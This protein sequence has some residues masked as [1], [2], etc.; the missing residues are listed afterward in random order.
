MDLCHGVFLCGGGKASNDTIEAGSKS[1]NHYHIENASKQC[2]VFWK[3]THFEYFWKFQKQRG[4][5]IPH[6][7]YELNP[8]NSFKYSN[9]FMQQQQYRVD[10][11]AQ[12]PA[13]KLKT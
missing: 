5:C 13:S 8:D 11:C 3:S 2:E 7:H 1:M 12:L 9:E 4:K 6:Q 10:V